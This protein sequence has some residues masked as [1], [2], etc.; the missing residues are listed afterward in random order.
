[1]VAKEIL[2]I[3]EICAPLPKRY[4]PSAPDDF[5]GDLIPLINLGCRSNNIDKFAIRFLLCIILS[6]TTICLSAMG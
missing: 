2:L 3:V 4:F 1:M 6:T 5:A